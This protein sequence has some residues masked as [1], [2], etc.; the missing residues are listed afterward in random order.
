M[1]K[2]FLILAILWTLNHI[3]TIIKNPFI[4]YLLNERIFLFWWLF[5]II[6][7]LFY[8]IIAFEKIPTKGFHKLLL[9]VAIFHLLISFFQINI[10]EFTQ[11]TIHHYFD[12]SYIH[13]LIILPGIFITTLCGILF[14]YN[15][16]KIPMNEFDIKNFNIIY[17]IFFFFGLIFIIPILD[18]FSIFVIFFSFIIISYPLFILLLSFKDKFRST[19][20]H[21]S[22]FIA[23]FVILLGIIIDIISF[24]RLGELLMN[25]I[26]IL[27]VIL[28][29][30][31]LLTYIISLIKIIKKVKNKL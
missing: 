17:F 28:L 6:N 10:F 15:Y 21:L 13:A 7:T 12:L 4:E 22:V 2:L 31:L 26:I 24:S 29:I 30:S 25:K 20:S 19:W 18:F 27:F 23:A 9:F 1:K 14:Y 3:H 8:Y 5:A 11:K 16:K